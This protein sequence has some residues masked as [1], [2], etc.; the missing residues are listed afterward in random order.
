MAPR[1][2]TSDVLIAL[3][4]L[5]PAEARLAIRLVNG[6]SLDEAAISLGVSRNTAK[7][8]LRAVFSKT[9]VTRQPQLIQ[10]ILNSVVTLAGE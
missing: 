6:L 4:G 2:A 5:T 9:G 8:H 1:Q 7:S 3:F 10:L